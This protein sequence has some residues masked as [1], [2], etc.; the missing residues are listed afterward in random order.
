MNGVRSASA[1]FR[2]RL[3]SPPAYGVAGRGGAELLF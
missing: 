2:G 1:V 3:K